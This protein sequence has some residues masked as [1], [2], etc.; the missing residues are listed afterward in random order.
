MNPRYSVFIFFLL[1][2]LSSGSNAAT[3]T[4]SQYNGGEFYL[5]DCLSFAQ[6]ETAYFCSGTPNE[7]SYE[8]SQ[9][10][11]QTASSKFGRSYTV[12]RTPITIEYDCG[13]TD[14]EYWSNLQ[15][16]LD[17]ADSANKCPSG[18]YSRYDVCKDDNHC[19]IGNSLDTLT[20][21][22]VPDDCS[23]GEFTSSA[24]ICETCPIGTQCYVEPEPEPEPLDP[25]ESDP[26]A[27]GCPGY[28]D[29]DQPTDGGTGGGSDGSGAGGITVSPGSNDTDNDGV[30]NDSDTESN[31]DLGSGDPSTGE[32][33]SIPNQPNSGSLPTNDTGDTSLSGFTDWLQSFLTSDN[34]ITSENATQTSD[35]RS[36]IESRSVGVDLSNLA[37]LDSTGFLAE[38]CPADL[39]VSTSFGTVTISMSPICDFAS[40]IKPLLIA[41]VTYL[42]YMRVFYSLVEVS[43]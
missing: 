23:T 39:Q 11:T 1:C 43:S 25:C 38:S 21:T 15:Q 7:F 22:C 2:S 18:F 12:T 40:L 17:N 37:Q 13:V 8:Y 19:V 36:E 33:H 4:L 41:L 24:G 42:V 31:L 6:S 27:F 9:W 35:L 14:S 20:G 34:G 16:F 26:T 10:C 5:S 3:F 32:D 28:L 30:P 29:P